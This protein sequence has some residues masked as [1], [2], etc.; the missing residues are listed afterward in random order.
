MYKRQ[1]I[2]CAH[3]D[4]RSEIPET[5]APGA[6]DNG[7]GT[8]ATLE[9]ARVLKDYDFEATIRYVCFSREEQGLVGSQAYVADAYERGDNILGALNFDM[10]GYEDVDPEDV[11]I[12]C[13]SFSQ[14]LGDAYQNAVSLYVPD[15]SVVRRTANYVGS[16][17][18]SFWD[19]GYSSFCGIEDMPLNNPNYHRTSDRIST[20]DFE[21]YGDVVRG[22][23]A[24]LAELATLDTVL[25]SIATTTVNVPVRIEPNPTRGDVTI[26]LSQAIGANADAVEI[27]DV[28]GR[29]VKR[30]E[31]GGRTTQATWKGT[32]ADGRRVSPGIY[33]VTLPKTGFVTKLVVL[34]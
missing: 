16:D 3:Y 7:T 13:N 1:Y 32:A 31:L 17:N 9:A 18:S 22:A 29:M 4:D 34:N 15:L 30:I 6:D 25:S 2:I 24:T 8:V 14:W 23:V 21:F 10:I 26:R 12:I 5:Y 19:Y 33:F 28:R 27:Y 20:L 11:D